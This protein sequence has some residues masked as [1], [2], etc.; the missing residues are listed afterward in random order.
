MHIGDQATEDETIYTHLRHKVN[1]GK[2]TQT[3]G[4]NRPVRLTLLA[5]GA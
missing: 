3:V 5:T 2:D 4:I 1:I